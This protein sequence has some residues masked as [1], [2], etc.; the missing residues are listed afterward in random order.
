[1]VEGPADDVAYRRARRY[2]DDTQ[3][4][5]LRTSGVNGALA[6]QELWS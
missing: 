3:A 1:M 2:R 5:V 4:R 6:V